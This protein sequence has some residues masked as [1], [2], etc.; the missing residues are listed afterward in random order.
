MV[1]DSV[2]TYS[3]THCNTQIHHT[4]QTLIQSGISAFPQVRIGE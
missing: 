2:N 3:C 4:S 1:T